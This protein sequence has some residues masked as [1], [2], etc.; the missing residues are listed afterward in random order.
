MDRRILVLAFA[1]FAVGTQAY[2]FAGLL[3]GL[4]ADL[5][6][7]V[8]TA[9]QL[10]SAF[11]VTFALTA[12]FTA[13][14]VSRFERRRVIVCGLLALGGLNVLAAL[15]PRFDLL[16]ALRIVCG[17]ASTFVIPI[18]SAAAAQLAGPELRGRALAVVIG[19]TTLAFVLGIPT[20]SA[21]GGAFGWRAT[22]AY[23]GL[24]GCFAAVVIAAVVP[25]VRPSSARRT[26]FRNALT[27]P[28]MRYILLTL[29]AFA[30][31]FTVTAYI[32]PVVGLTTGARGGTVGWF[33]MLVG[34]GSLIGIAVGG[35]AADRASGFT[36]VGLL[37]GLM[38][39][40]LSV[41]SVLV[42]RGPEAAGNAWLLGSVIIGGAAA[43][44]AVA[45]IV[46]AGLVEAAPQASAVVLALNGSALFLGQGLGA[47]IG[48][49]V[50]ATAGYAALGVVAASIAA[51]AALTVLTTFPQPHRRYA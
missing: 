15:A 16:L 29:A 40:T 10:A 19:G 51:V 42:L 12:P 30:A 4:A 24:L 46:Q 1:S 14:W 36:P 5:E 32:G 43:L 7:S 25:P 41:Y 35:R 6:V 47:A 38:T 45:P 13:T 39:I 49:I 28:V 22:F 26:P 8:A 21:I 20:G 23:A 34:F 2:V 48:G 33:Q 11:A 37:F 44:F 9:G 27:G 3:D 17:L 31:T 50:I 18:A